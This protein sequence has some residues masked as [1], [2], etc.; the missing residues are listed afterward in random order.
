MKK[1]F[2]II[3]VA[4][5]AG[6]FNTILPV[7]KRM[8]KDKRFNVVVW[9]AGKSSDLAKKNNIKS[10]KNPIGIKLL[11]EKENPDLIFTATSCGLS[12]EKKIIKASKVPTIS[13]VDFW[14]NYSVRFGF[15]KQYVSD[16]IL[17]ID[18]IMK[19]ELID[20]GIEK[21]KIFITGNPCFDYLY[22]VK[23]ENNNL[24]CF[25]SQPFSELDKTVNPCNFNEVKIFRDIIRVLE[26]IPIPFKVIIKIHPKGENIGKFSE[27]I[28]NSKLSIKIEK[29]LS[30][31]ELIKK[32]SIIIGINSMAL[33][34]SSLMG[35]KTIS[36]QPGLK[37]K[38]F[39]LSNKLGLS[40]LARNEKELQIAL[41]DKE[42]F[43]LKK[44]II[45]RY[46]RNNATEKVIEFICQIL[47]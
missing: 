29:N 41:T 24:V 1:D 15:K 45:E 30:T 7:I 47:K 20:F 14:S 16:Y 34:I 39:L 17:V 25:F 44:D 21:N 3:F 8:K 12:L 42:P 43:V 2:K 6:G 31:E 35:R 18:Q 38:D 10:L 46:A 32:S 36:F 26:R 37:G 11:L 28:K 22:L 23:E 4:Q 27:I 5:D 33:F 40:V 13:I 19:K 9:V